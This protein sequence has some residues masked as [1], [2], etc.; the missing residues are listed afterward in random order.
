VLRFVRQPVRFD[1]ETG[2]L[3]V[4]AENNG[5]PIVIEIAQTALEYAARAT[6]QGKDASLLALVGNKRKF[7]RAAGH[8]IRRRGQ[9][10]GVVRVL[11]TD[12]LTAHLPFFA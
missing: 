9:H 3:I 10:A 8:A 12:L 4:F 5:E 1:D 2:T 6:V 7:L 11:A